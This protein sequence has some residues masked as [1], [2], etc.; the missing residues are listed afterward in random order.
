LP[1]LWQGGHLELLQHQRLASLLRFISVCLLACSL[2]VGCHRSVG[3]GIERANDLLYHQKYVDAERLYRKLLHRLDAVKEPNE[4]DEAQRLLVLDRLGKL[5]GLYLRDYT[6]AIADYEVLIRRYPGNDAALS[7][8]WSVADLYTHKVAD[9]HSAIG[10]YQRL[11]SQFGHHP[12]APKAL[13]EIVGCYFRLKDYNQVRLEAETL[14]QR[15]PGTPEAA[16]ARFEMANAYYVQRRYTE[17][18]A[19]YEAVL[20]AKPDPELGALVDYELG[21]CYQELG[22][23]PRALGSYYAALSHHPSPKLVQSKI[24]RVRAQLHQTR[25][26]AR[27]ANAAVIL[28]IVSPVQVVPPRR[29]RIKK[30]VQQSPSEVEIGAIPGNNAPLPEL[31]AESLPQEPT[32]AQ[33]PSE[34][35]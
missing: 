7:A 35:P 15:Y 20:S 1:H 14:C 10:A 4:A 19:T 13:L 30:S 5:N 3:D 33:A 22:Q 18:I 27:I 8:L 16:Q 6:Q 17:A 12:E 29:P 25:P 34:S 23:T 21:N 32:E 9:L 2:I 28:P 24:V 11:V 26:A 31:P